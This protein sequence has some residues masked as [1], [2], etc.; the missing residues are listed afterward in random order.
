MKFVLIFFM[1]AIS[2]NASADKWHTDT[3]KMIYPLADGGFVLTFATFPTECTNGSKYFY[4]EIGQRSMTI[5]GANK[6]YSLAMM[7]MS[8]GKK[9]S[10]NYDE[11]SSSCYINRAYVTN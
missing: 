10:I 1:L 5:E 11:N 7:A 3:I 8:T 6:I 2:L 4:T 9:L